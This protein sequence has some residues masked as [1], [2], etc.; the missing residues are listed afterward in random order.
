MAV[1]SVR[2]LKTTDSEKPGGWLAL[3]FVA[4]VA[5][6]E[7][8]A[9]MTRARTARAM[10]SGHRPP[11][12]RIDLYEQPC[13]TSSPGPAALRRGEAKTDLTTA[14]ASRQVIGP[15]TYRNP[16]TNGAWTPR[17]EQCLAPAAE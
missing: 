5:C 13:M 7:P 4:P 1:G 6:P 14:A 8:P 12:A 9:A 17:L 15:A 3:A 10:A 16:A 2:P 11:G